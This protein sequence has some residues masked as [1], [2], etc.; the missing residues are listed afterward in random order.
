M[1]SNSLQ[2]LIT[3]LQERQRLDLIRFSINPYIWKSS[4]VSECYAMFLKT[5][6]HS[7]AG[8]AVTTRIEHIGQLEVRLTYLFNAFD[9]CM[10]YTNLFDIYSF[11][12]LCVSVCVCVYV[13]CACTSSYHLKVEQV[14]HRELCHLIYISRMEVCGIQRISSTEVFAT[15]F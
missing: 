9:I 13:L 14:L 2:I 4:K 5:N 1:P 12:S 3:K 8:F 11:L 7:K 15:R 6:N 10:K